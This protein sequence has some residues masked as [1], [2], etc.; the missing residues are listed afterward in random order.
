MVSVMSSNPTGGYF[1][2][3]RHLDA[4]FVQKW[5]KCQI[6]VIYENLE[7]F[8]INW[9]VPD[10]IDLNYV[11]MFAEFKGKWENYLYET[12]RISN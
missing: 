1:I 5:Q 7:S 2:F 11:D 10:N 8:S 6:C 3:L 4:N 12:F 9:R